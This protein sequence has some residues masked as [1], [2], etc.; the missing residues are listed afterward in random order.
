V[1]GL[2]C[3]ALARGEAATAEELLRQSVHKARAVGDTVLV[4]TGLHFLGEA[5]LAQGQLAEGEGRLK[6]ALELI[7]THGDHCGRGHTLFSLAHLALVRGQLA[8]AATLQLDSLA[9]RRLVGDALG[10]SHCLDEL[11][12]VATARGDLVRAA[13]LFA[14]AEAVRVPIGGG[15]WPPRS[16]G[17]ERAL[18]LTRSGLG[19]DALEQAWVVGSQLILDEALAEAAALTNEPPGN[20]RSRSGR[21]SRLGRSEPSAPQPVSTRHAASHGP[22]AAPC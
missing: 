12:C 14:A 17:R 18:D 9:V 2:G 7:E 13:R 4:Y 15:V 19:E 3:C 22:A 20:E 10:V 8:R 5:M 11:A 21:L 16:A 1:H 6:Q